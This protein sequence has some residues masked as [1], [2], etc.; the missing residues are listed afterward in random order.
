MNSQ[1][2]VQFDQ[3]DEPSR[4]GGGRSRRF[5]AGAAVAAAVAVGGLTVAAFN[6]L[7]VV[8]A[9]GE[10][11]TTEAPAEQPAAP[12][13]P[14]AQPA[15]PEAP[16]AQPAQPAVPDSGAGR[17]GGVNKVLDDSLAALVADGTLT[18]AQADAV[19]AKVAET[20]KA[21]FGER[22]GGRGGG[23]GPGFGPKLDAAAAALGIDLE[24][25]RTE[26]RSGKSL[27][28][29]A[30]AHGV[31][32]ATV[33]DALVSAANE[34]IDAAVADGKVDAAKAAELKAR[35][36]EWIQRLVAEGFRFGRN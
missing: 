11:T 32:A 21:A 27:S 12:E 35:S 13:A 3:H 10:T 28:E 25:L 24:A 18:Q 4:S 1:D 16:A 8:G 26:L 6:P 22:R 31:D 9:Q 17:R 36:A 14:A 15:E 19:K 20:A 29:I 2:G 34:M 23:H 33:T 30:E 5:M 7:G